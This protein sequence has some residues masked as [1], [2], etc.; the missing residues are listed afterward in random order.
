MRIP[1]FVLTIGVVAIG[2]WPSLMS[3]LTVP[4][5]D[6]AALAER[7]RSLANEAELFARLSRAGRRTVEDRFG[8]QRM[9]DEIERHLLDVSSGSGV[10]Q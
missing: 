1:L 2:L 6:A 4:A 9:I 5:G 10:G 7:V 8:E 3:W